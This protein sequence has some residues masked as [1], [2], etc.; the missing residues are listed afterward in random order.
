MQLYNAAL[1]VQR[2]FYAR[3][4]EF[5]TFALCCALRTS[6]EREMEEKRHEELLGRWW[7]VYR[8]QLKFRGLL[9]RRRTRT[10][11]RLQKAALLVQRNF[12]AFSRWSF[13]HQLVAKTRAARACQRLHRSRHARRQRAACRIQVRPA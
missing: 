3:S 11:V 8:L 1:R 12:R 9:R 10:T 7:V 2:R 6:H 4:G 13:T 5:S